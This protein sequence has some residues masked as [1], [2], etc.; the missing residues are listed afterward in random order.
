LA[1]WAREGEALVLKT[2]N[3]P[4]HE[5]SVNG[6]GEL[7]EMDLKLVAQLLGAQPEV[8]ERLSTGSNACSYVMKIE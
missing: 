2:R 7:C 1:D 5:A 8:R 3:C 6:H 4:Y